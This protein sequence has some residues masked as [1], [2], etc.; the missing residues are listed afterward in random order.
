[1]AGLALLM[2]PVGFCA[3]GSTSCI[4]NRKWC[5]K[6]DFIFIDEQNVMD[7]AVFE[8]NTMIGYVFAAP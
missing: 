4:F 2:S 5:S 8:G 1:M 3:T 7:R 6:L